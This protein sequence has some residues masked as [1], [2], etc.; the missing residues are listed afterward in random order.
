[1]HQ[2]HRSFHQQ[3]LMAA[4]G[5]MK[6]VVERIAKE[7]GKLMIEPPRVSGNEAFHSNKLEY[8][9]H[10]DHLRD[11]PAKKCK[12]ANYRA[13]DRVDNGVREP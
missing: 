3:Q 12:R 6:A 2:R 1:M 4:G 8:G 9:K 10:E 5:Q 7:W 13:S 11:E